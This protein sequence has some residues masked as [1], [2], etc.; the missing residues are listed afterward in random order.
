MLADK[1]PGVKQSPFTN[2]AMM[3]NYALLRK[4]NAVTD[5][6][7]V[8]EHDVIGYGNALS[9]PDVMGG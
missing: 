4:V 8:T 2:M 6:T 9:H 5:N 3:R 7:M 1:C